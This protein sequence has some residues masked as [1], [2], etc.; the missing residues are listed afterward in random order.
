MLLESHKLSPK[1]WLAHF[2][3][4]SIS[5]P[6]DLKCH[7]GS[8]KTYKALF[9]NSTTSE[10]S[11]SIQQLLSISDE[12]LNEENSKP[13]IPSDSE[14]KKKEFIEFLQ[15]LGLTEQFPKKLKVKDAMLL[16]KETLSNI[17]YTDE[18]T[19]LPYLILQKIFM[20][21]NRSRA[22]LFKE[23]NKSSSIRKIHPIDSFLTLIHC[24][25]NFL[26]QELLLKVSVCQM[27]IP[28]LLPNPH[29]NSVIFLLWAM[30]SIIKSW[31]SYNKV[32]DTIESK[33][34]RITEYPAPVISFLK[35]GKSKKSK[36]HI[37]NEVISE[38]NEHY[39]FN[40]NCEGGGLKRLFVDGLCE[41]C[42]Y[43]PSGKNNFDDF[44][45]DMLLFLNLRGDAQKHIKQTNFI[46]EVSYMIFIL[47]NEDDINEN[48]LKLLN[49]LSSNSAGG[50]VLMFP[51]L[52]NDQP[53]KTKEIEQSLCEMVIIKLSGKNDVDIRNEVRET[54]LQKLA[55]PNTKDCKSL[56]DCIS[57]AHKLQ[58]HVDEYDEDCKKGKY[59]AQILM[60]KVKSI[61]ITKAK[62]EMLP[63]QGSSLWHKWATL[64]K[65]SFRQLSRE[66]ADMRRY[67]KQKD[68]EKKIIRQKQFE[69]SKNPKPVMQNFLTNLLEQKGNTRLYFLQWIKM[70]LDDYS[71][72]KLPDLSA[73]YHKTRVKLIEANEASKNTQSESD[74]V[75]KLKQLLKN[76]NEE[77]INASFGLEH[78]FREMGQIYE[79][80]MDPQLK[81]PTDFKN[82]VISYPQI[83]VD[84]MEEGYP[85]EL[86]D[87]DASHVPKLWILAIIKR[88]KH[89]YVHSSKIFVISVLGI[90]STGKSTLL[91][92]VFGL[93]FNV[94]AGRCTRGAY[95]QLLPLN[96]TL[97]EQTNFHHI[98]IVDTEGL[99]APEL[100]YQDSQKHDNELA[101]FVIGLADLTIINIYGE[102]PGDLT[103]ILET[104]VHAFIRMKKIEMQLSCHFVHQNVPS[105]MADKKGKFGRQQFNDKLDSMTKTAAEGEQLGGVY[106]HFQ[107]VIHFN[108]ETD[109][110][111]FPSLWKGDPPMAPVNQGYSDKACSLKKALI[112]LAEQKNHSTFDKFEIRVSRLWQAVL[113]EK[114]VFSFK[115]TLEV[116]AYNEL[117]TE[118]SK[119]AWALKRKIL[120]W[121]ITSTNVINS[122][123]PLKLQETTESSL[124]MAHDV[125]NATYLELTREMNSFFE[126]SEKSDTLAQ[127]RRRTEIRLETMLEVHQ[128]AAKKY[129]D[130]LKYTREGRVKVDQ[131]RQDYRQQLHECITAITLNAQKENFTSQQR[132]KFFDE[133]WQQWLKGLS[134]FAN[135]ELYASES[136]IYTNITKILETLFS[137]HNQLI[138]QKL[139]KCPLSQCDN[140]LQLFIAN[141]HLTS[142]TGVYNR[143]RNA[144]FGKDV[145]DANKITEQFLYNAREKIEEVVCTLQ[146]YDSNVVDEI[147]T[148]LLT[149]IY[150]QNEENKSYK[151][152]QEYC[153]DICIVVAS[154]A[155]KAMIKMVKRL[156]IQN[157]PIES[158]TK[159]KP[160]FFRTFESQF[161]AASN[162]TTAADNLCELLS[163][164]IQTALV[165]VLRIDIV[166]D[167]KS[168]ANFSKK[169]YFKALV[170][171]DLAKKD[172]FNL[173]CTFLT[174]I[175]SSFKYWAKFYVENH[176]KVKK[177]GETKFTQL[178]KKSLTTIIHDIREA[179]NKLEKKYEHVSEN[180]DTDSINEGTATDF[181]NVSTFSGDYNVDDEHDCNE[182]EEEEK[183]EV[184]DMN[185]WLE[186]FLQKIKET[187]T[188][189]LQ[190]IQ[191]MIGIKDLQNLKLFT[192][193]F[194]K[195]LR[196][197]ENTIIKESADKNSK[198]AKVTEWDLS[199]HTLLSSTLTGCKESCPFCREQ[200]ECTDEDHEGNSHFTKIHRPECLG[201][202]TWEGTN[203]LVLDICSESIE[204]ECRFRNSDTKHEWVPYKDYK[205]IYK[206]WVIS[207][208][209]PKEGQTYWQWFCAKYNSQIVN[210]VASNPTPVKSGWKSI[211]KEEAIHSLSVMYGTKA[212]I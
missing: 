34:Y 209:A 177:H 124:K 159:L 6:E 45:S 142:A 201:R 152:T 205:T 94:S 70:F 88:L 93:H 123:E 195:N 102:T 126:K 136:A 157:D 92:T 145:Q 130:I 133:Q 184:V 16:R 151:F 185:I 107:D 35:L 199:P 155:A 17:R 182:M 170:L 211:T 212:D 168:N 37:I 98:L 85:V 106:R 95:F 72:K 156:R 131:I 173:F 202:T 53:F 58:I 171:E 135:T 10:E 80:R 8:L 149:A 75:K 61:D 57:I 41:M 121:Q 204:S 50:I 169:G 73:T 208:E 146:H 38:S 29:D 158:L 118:Y 19:I 56:S 161:S 44:Y 186:E 103:D 180:D 43:L 138:I 63:L 160:I 31:K 150:Q 83:I 96:N 134:R 114:F 198:L 111:F 33:E 28:L 68:A 24:S 196:Q 55:L 166:Q 117:D 12:K 14:N 193:R 206:N 97:R 23:T 54:M 154:Y 179:A 190:E 11:L 40:W 137:K 9:Q 52:E 207:N 163:I 36:S 87:G 167:M 91:N 125:L 109:V 13:K 189:D 18:V 69:L 90:Q 187:V 65:E 148:T 64:D 119:W 112:T 49:M 1:K 164:P 120:E 127:W 42:S 4:M 141:D 86:M 84:L 140:N 188:I 48:S 3:K 197:V 115:N 27:A 99:R 30:R 113:R 26:C 147:L 176:C 32:E 143:V 132:E 153:V 60:K 78:L 128:E 181:T 71:R 22:A 101:T 15:L 194:I 89:T 183:K 67:S 66:D 105:I 46:R 200:C 77:L 5:Q 122:C 82:K 74:E 25:D 62:T 47:L 59:L 165:K 110:M 139:D 210:W 7:K 76:Q 129:C 192:K 2:N 104:A 21:D 178:V 79:A 191:E 162:D 174:D 144:V 108:S 51:D 20:Y 172:D 39:F 203:L 175:D 100:Q 116:I 81:V